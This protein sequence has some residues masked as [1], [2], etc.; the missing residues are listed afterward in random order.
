MT[1]MQELGMLL[2][3]I[4]QVKCAVRADNTVKRER[5]FSEIG[6]L[7]FTLKSIIKQSTCEACQG[8]GRNSPMPDDPCMGCS[9]SGVQH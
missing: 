9:G 1:L 8:D 2:D 6:S 7:E 3:D 4:E 5:A